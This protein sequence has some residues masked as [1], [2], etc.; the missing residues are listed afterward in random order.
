MSVSYRVDF[1]LSM[2]GSNRE[3]NGGSLYIIC[4]P[5]DVKTQ[6]GR[7]R[8]VWSWDLVFITKMPMPFLLLT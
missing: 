3:Q 5:P 7:Y 8:F 4:A 6:E 1:K 2:M